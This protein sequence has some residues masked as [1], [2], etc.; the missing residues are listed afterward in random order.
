LLHLV[1]NNL[2][3]DQLAQMKIEQKVQTGKENEELDL[4]YLELQLGGKR[5]DANES[6]LQIIYVTRDMI[7]VKSGRE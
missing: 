1:Q 7:S 2:D 3:E 5:T 6:C 4:L